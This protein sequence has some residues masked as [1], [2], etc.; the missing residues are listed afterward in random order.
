M[1]DTLAMPR[2]TTKMP[3]KETIHGIVR[4]RALSPMNPMSASSM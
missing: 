3:K 2:G 1:R 4:H